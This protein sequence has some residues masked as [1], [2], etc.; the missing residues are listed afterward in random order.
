[1]IEFLLLPTFLTL[2]MFNEQA[3]Y[4]SVNEIVLM[5]YW[6]LYCINLY[7]NKNHNILNLWN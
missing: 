1:M 4:I 3:L 7:F 5:F 6:Y 2:G